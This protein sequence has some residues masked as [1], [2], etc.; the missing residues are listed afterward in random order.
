M[1]K[2]ISNK[3]QWRSRRA[4]FACNPA[5]QSL[6]LLEAKCGGDPFGYECTADGSFAGSN[7]GSFLG[8]SLGV[9]AG[10]NCLGRTKKMQPNKA[11]MRQMVYISTERAQTWACSE[12]A[13]TFNPSGPPRG[14]SLEEMKQNY[15][16]QRDK[17]YAS[18]VCTE[19][20]RNKSAR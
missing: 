12:C 5:G 6:S 11:S 13:W 18:H 2:H 14:G 4:P 15:E 20:S 3:F 10:T 19:H 8:D 9:A 7:A 16:R 17:E 1:E